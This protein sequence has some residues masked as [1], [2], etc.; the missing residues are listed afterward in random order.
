ME[1][2]FRNKGALKSASF[3]G[4]LAIKH[5]NKIQSKLS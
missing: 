2:N 1:T 5:G 4:D 3:M